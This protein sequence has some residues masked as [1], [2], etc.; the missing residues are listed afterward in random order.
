MDL[1]RSK[2]ALVRGLEPVVGRLARAGVSP[3]AVTLAAVPVGIV[4]GGCLLLS[5]AVPA[6]LLAIPLLA[7]VRL[8]LNL[9]DGALARQTGRT[10]ALGE[11]YNELGDRLADI[12]FL[13]PVAFLPGA[14]Q[15][16]VL[17]GVL[18]AVL[19]SFA[20]LAPRAAGGDRIY[21][22]ILSKPGRMALLS[23][24]AVAALVAGPAAWGPFGP[25]LLIGTTLTAI[26]RIVVG[27]RRLA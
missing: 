12:A 16:L 10:H 17:L 15:P 7:L 11:L 4:A 27:I 18:G 19:A 25:L 1:Y 6:L 8:V 21:R 13:A 26:E 22:G 5:P 2:S 9:L 24:F 14:N 23:V 20:G 3:D